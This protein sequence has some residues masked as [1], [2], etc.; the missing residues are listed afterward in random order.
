MP[1]DKKELIKSGM[2]R[3]TMTDTFKN[4]MDT[5]VA[6]EG[7]AK[8]NHEWELMIAGPEASRVIG[9]LGQNVNQM[10][11]SP[12]GSEFISTAYTTA[13]V[14]LSK[15]GEETRTS[16]LGKIL[17]MAFFLFTSPEMPEIVN[18][19]GE[20][21]V[22]AVNKPDAPLFVRHFWDEVKQSLSDG[23]LNKKLDKCYGNIFSLMNSYQGRGK[24]GTDP[25]QAVFKPK[26]RNTLK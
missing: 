17:S 1:K 7:L 15:A 8:L 26:A 19:T 2:V 24:G 11:T 21:I 16:G 22:T 6:T 18:K 9:T 10:L 20:L 5:A 3:G 12:G 23:N 25:Q 14:L 13:H 4:S